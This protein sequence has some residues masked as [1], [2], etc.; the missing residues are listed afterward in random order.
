[1]GALEYTLKQLGA[2]TQIKKPKTF[3]DRKKQ[4]EQDY[5]KL[6]ETLMN[7]SSFYHDLE[8]IKRT[9]ADSDLRA[10]VEKYKK[11]AETTCQIT[12]V[13][14]IFL[15][16]YCENFIRDDLFRKIKVFDFAIKEVQRCLNSA[17][18]DKQNPMDEINNNN[19]QQFITK[20]K[21]LKKKKKIFKKEEKIDQI[22][23]KKE[24]IITVEDPDWEMIHNAFSKEF[25]NELSYIE[26]D[27]TSDGW[28][29]FSDQVIN[30]INYSLVFNPEYQPNIFTI[31]MTEQLL[32]N[33]E[34]VVGI[35]DAI[36]N[37][38]NLQIVNLI[39]FPKDSNGNLVENFGLDGLI[40]GNLFKLVQAVS[41]NRSIKAFLLHS[42]NN[43]NIVMAPEI[44]DVILKKLQS[45]T[46]VFFHL[47]NFNISEG[48]QKKFLF[49]FSSTR[50]LS[51]LSIE[52]H[53]WAEK[54]VLNYFKTI[55]EKNRSLLCLAVVSKLFANGYKEEVEEKN[56][57]NGKSVRNGGE[58]TYES[59]S[60]QDTQDYKKS[61]NS[62]IKIEGELEEVVKKT[63]RKVQLILRGKSLV[64]LSSKKKGFRK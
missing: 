33:T 54:E 23:N 61:K 8:N 7:K 32:A 53:N 59:Q 17:F 52:N 62:L 56:G 60:S 30:A 21:Y 57:K 16:L 42:A 35:S 6:R 43:Y 38:P 12:D 19:G 64:N 46:L 1:M 48:Y 24:E 58:E 27:I 36:Q 9:K 25:E 50:A 34:Y 13:G 31:Y 22:N 51:F 11:E 39:L 26:Y 28:K 4:Y 63:K 3:A 2:E 49:Q 18:P 45:E 15:S 14:Y 20:Q 55:L 40:Y 29:S 37:C 47:G 5:K 10:F 44:C 41:L